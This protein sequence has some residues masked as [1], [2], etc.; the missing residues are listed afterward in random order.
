MNIITCFC[1]GVARKISCTSRRISASFVSTDAPGACKDQQRT[2]LV[3]H[4]V[5]L[6]K[7]ELLDGAQA[8]G[9]L[10]H[11][12]VET[13]GSRHDDVRVS[14]LVLQ[15]L[16]V[17]LDGGTAVKDASLDVREVLGEAGVFILDLVGQLSG[18]A[19][20][21]DGAF[22]ID[23]LDLLEGGK[24]KD[25]GFT[26]TRLGLGDDIGSEDRL[27]DRLSL[28][29]GLRGYVRTVSRSVLA[30]REQAKGVTS[31]R[32]SMERLV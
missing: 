21:E 12:S 32:P 9:L 8:K 24:D 17:L 6:V 31:V 5:T 28:N 1:V 26:K 19:H 30:G 27:W 18:V 2:D 22:A 29:C 4:L 11:Q 13:A 20:D 15:N 3:K 25:G 7:H 23:R 10:A 16:L 14:L